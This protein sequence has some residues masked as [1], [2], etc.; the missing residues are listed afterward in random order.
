MKRLI[1]LI[2]MQFVVL[3]ISGCSVPIIGFSK[4]I[5]GYLPW[6]LG[7][8]YFILL[9]VIIILIIKYSAKRK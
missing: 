5:I 6:P 7:L 1:L 4:E 2:L 8:A 9:F 3:S